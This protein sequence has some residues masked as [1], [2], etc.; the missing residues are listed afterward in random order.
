MAKLRNDLRRILAG[1]AY[2]VVLLS[3]ASNAATSSPWVDSPHSAVRLVSAGTARPEDKLP[4]GSRLAGIEVRLTPPFITYWRSPGDAGVPPAFAFAGSDNLNDVRVEFPAPMRLD[5]GGSQAFGYSGSVTFP[6]VIT[7]KD[8]ARPVKLDLVFDYA[9]CANVCLP[10]KANLSLDLDAP[11]SPQADIVFDA[12]AK[13][14][15]KRRLAE[16]GGIRIDAVR[17]NPDGGFEVRATTPDGSGTLFVE[18]P[19]PWYLTASASRPEGDGHMRFTLT[20]PDPRTGPMPSEPV[21]LTL[22][23]P[24]GAIE[25]P[26]RLDAPPPKP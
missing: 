24:A 12:L 3:S 26:V 9:T 2:G 18:A 13:V 20:A 19:E 14:P 15:Q 10:A 1:G 25:V 17:P 22:V 16:D 7:A 11:T 4:P 21:R 6:L 5:E 23:S 8:P